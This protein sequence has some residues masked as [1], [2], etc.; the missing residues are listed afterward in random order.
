MR[1]VYK[2]W[3][4]ARFRTWLIVFFLM[5]SIIPLGALG[6]IV[7]QLA[8]AELT[9]QAQEHFWQNAKNT[10]A[11]LDNELDYIEEFSLK[12]NA[13]SR[14]YDIFREL[15]TK[16]GIQLEEASRQITRILLNYL[17]WNNSVYSTH[18]VTSYY[19][20]GEEE[21]NFYPK[22]SFVESKM[23]KQAREADGKLVWIPTYNYMEMFRIS[24][25]N[26]NNLEYKRLFSAVRKLNPSHIAS[27]RILHLD[28]DVERPY[29]VINFTEENLR[30]MLR[31]Y[32]RKENEAE[33]YVVTEQ[34]EMVCSS[35][36]EAGGEPAG[37]TVKDIG[38]DKESDCIRRKIKGEDYIIAYAR[39]EV[40]GWYVVASLPVKILTE[41][42]ADNLMRVILALILLMTVLS[43]GI[44]FF[45]SKKL[46]KK[47]YKPLNMIESVGAGNFNTVIHY[48]PMDEF[49]FFYQKLNEMN[50]NLKNLVHE[51][52][53][54]KL[55]KRDT[56]IMAL[57]IQ[58]NPHF[59]YNSLN[60]INWACL[61][62]DNE[63]ASG[64]LLDLSRMLR[65]TSRSREL[66]V[67]L[68]E[69]L[70]WLKRYLGIMEKRYEKRFKA[71]ISIPEVLEKLQVPKLFLQPFVENAIIHA[72]EE[73]QEDGEIRI[74]AEEENEDIVF[75]V[76]DNGCGIPQG[77]ISEIFSGKNNSI[78]IQN[79]DK[80]LRMIY[81]EKYGVSISS[82]VGEGTTVFIRVPDS[83]KNIQEP[84]CHF[85]KKSL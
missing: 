19:R 8:K 65:Y 17:P 54:V 51:N 44:S 14:L 78:G 64:M 60:I 77:K 21:K 58:M 30:N 83:R 53:E 82:Q 36:A 79:T 26:E 47:I 16:N 45:I 20:F 34:G 4:Y 32:V 42:I 46:D 29:L 23:L 57:N 50:Q 37:I 39:S 10:S 68:Q 71:L 1:K 18:L 69:D 15:D 13:D 7:F 61:R 41:K 31:E 59:L 33:Y 85:Q 22:N 76:E 63:K 43:I 73:Y 6:I 80:R 38:I 55:R 28:S 27:G 35:G 49:A 67:I 25:I 24:G 52:F 72:F 2:R 74:S 11:L 84:P 40:T 62:G 12:M 75:C 9:K 81:G 66:M 56:E 70:D 3:K 48:H 5:F